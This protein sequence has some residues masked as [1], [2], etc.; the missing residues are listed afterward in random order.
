MVDQKKSLLGG[1]TAIV[2]GASRGIGRAIALELASEGAWV[3]INCA[4]NVEKA[5][6]VLAQIEQMKAN[7]SFPETAGGMVAQFSVFDSSAVEQAYTKLLE[8]RGGIDVLVNN[9]GITRDNLALRISDEDWDA[10][11]DTNLKGAFVCS[12]AAIRSMMK[13]R[14][15][16]IINVSS[17]VGEMGNSGQSNYCASKSGLFGLTKSLAKEVGSRQI[18]VNAV[19]PGFID[20][21]M[22][23]AL[24]EGAKKMMMDSI[25]LKRFGSGQDIARA[26]TW[27]AS[28]LSTYVTGQ[29]I[30]VNGGMYM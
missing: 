3:L 2:T 5:E 28:P 14:S 11:L 9:A 7:G 25:P 26:V 29:V 16:S 13:A 10:V 21:D 30:S 20:T 18:R 27:L 8:L 19:S 12:R 1:K 4:S 6:A 23:A 24:P 17:V 22:T 15:G